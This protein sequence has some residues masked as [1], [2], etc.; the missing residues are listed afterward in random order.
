M[1]SPDRYALALA[2]LEG[3]REARKIL[4]DLLEEQGER[5]LA[6][7]ARAG[8]SR[9]C[10]RV[11]FVLG[12][13]PWPR[14]LRLG[15]GFYLHSRHEL[16]PIGDS[17]Q[18]PRQIPILER[19][20]DGA[21]TRAAAEAAC[22]ELGELFV[23]REHFAHYSAWAREQRHWQSYHQEDS[24]LANLINASRFALSRSQAADGLDELGHAPWKDEVIAPVRRAVRRIR[25]AA[26]ETDVLVWQVE[27]AKMELR[28][29]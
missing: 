23:S 25:V 22:R 7:W 24:P 18:E 9:P 6:Q 14:T 4:A 21:E 1:H 16:P 11:D 29:L 5:G 15:W 8:K 28:R 13:L 3:D 27:Q 12:L 26:R 20:C 19:W 2:M 17:R 10:D